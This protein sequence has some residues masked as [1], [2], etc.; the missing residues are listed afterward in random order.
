MRSADLARAF[1]HQYA[2]TQKLI[3]QSKN[4]SYNRLKILWT[5]PI[6]I[7]EGRKFLKVLSP[8][9]LNLIFLEIFFPSQSNKY[10]Q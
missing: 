9:T 3:R 2:K 4:I 7:Q 6:T 8:T 1:Q 10:M 5:F